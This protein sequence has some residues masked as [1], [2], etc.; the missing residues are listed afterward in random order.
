MLTLWQYELSRWAALW[1]ADSLSE[2][3]GGNGTFRR[4]IV[5]G[6]E[7][8]SM[9][10]GCEGIHTFRSRRR[11]VARQNGTRDSALLAI[12]VSEDDST[13]RAQVYLSAN[14][15]DLCPGELK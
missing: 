8:I 3:S 9:A 11:P 13:Q 12:S 7:G 6:A 4:L 14:C 2:S 5:A 1:Q 10:Q 15:S